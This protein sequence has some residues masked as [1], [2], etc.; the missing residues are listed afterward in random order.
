MECSVTRHGASAVVTLR[1][2]LDVS[3]A[4]DLQRALSRVEA[5]CSEVTV[6]MRGVGFVDSTALGTL[7]GTTR[8]LRQLGGDL[9]LVVDDA[10]VLRV[11]R[12]TNLDSLIV[13][14]T[15]APADIAT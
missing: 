2:E 1:G 5:D 7:V 12:V 14:L 15:D 9:R 6:D 8:R 11:L 13:V 10:H 3:T 4:D